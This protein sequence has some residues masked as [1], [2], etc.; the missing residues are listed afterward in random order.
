MFSDL[1]LKEG[2]AQTLERAEN[3][4]LV[5]THQAAVAYDVSCEDCC[6][7]PF[8]TRLGHKSRPA[9]P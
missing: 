7:P 1:R 3:A 2:L 8:D 5:A 6:Q 4:F 9:A